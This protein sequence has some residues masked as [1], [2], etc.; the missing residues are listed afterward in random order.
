MKEKISYLDKI[1]TAFSF[2]LM[3]RGLLEEIIPNSD[4]EK[5][6]ELACFLVV[7]LLK[8]AINELYS[9]ENFSLAP[10]EVY[11]SGSVTKDQWSAICDSSLIDVDNQVAAHLRHLMTASTP[12][13]E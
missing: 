2:L 7:D 13:S 11:R 4:N 8:L 12:K 5:S 3:S 1:D 9:P 6:I 10:E